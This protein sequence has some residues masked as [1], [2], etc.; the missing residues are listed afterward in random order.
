MT[1]VQTCALPIYGVVFRYVGSVL[2][3]S[4][5]R[6]QGK[7]KF[8]SVFYKTFSLA[9]GPGRCYDEA[10]RGAAAALAGD[11]KRGGRAPGSC[12]GGGVRP[13]SA[14]GLRRGRSFPGIPPA[15]TKNEIEARRRRS[16]GSR[17]AGNAAEATP[18]NS[19]PRHG[20][21]VGPGGIP[22]GLSAALA[23]RGRYPLTEY[24]RGKAWKLSAGARLCR[25]FSVGKAGL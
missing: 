17:Q 23:L 8:F 22:S 11:G 15:E 20:R 24:A 6:S 18:P 4:Q 1:G 21:R 3:V 7:G 14:A 10:E 19:P 25:L 2:I 12:A 5:P 9:T 13:A 16:R